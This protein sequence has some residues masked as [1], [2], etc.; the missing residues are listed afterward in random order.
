[1]SDITK[2]KTVLIGN[3]ERKNELIIK[4]LERIS[5]YTYN[6]DFDKH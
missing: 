5:G 1:M 4:S 2:I 6:T 3:S